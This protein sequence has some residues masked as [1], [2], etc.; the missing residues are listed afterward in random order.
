MIGCV[1][2]VLAIPAAGEEPWEARWPT[3]DFCRDEEPKTGAP[4]HLMAGNWAVL[5]FNI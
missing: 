3:R 2:A 1:F 5:F 4:M